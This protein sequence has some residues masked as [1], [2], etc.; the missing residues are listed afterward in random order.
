M[1][2]LCVA[3]WEGSGLAAGSNMHQE[4]EFRRKG[5]IERKKNNDPYRKPSELVSP[6]ELFQEHNIQALKGW[7]LTGTDFQPFKGW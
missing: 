2:E 3:F 5:S 6:G 7:E 4:E 1:F